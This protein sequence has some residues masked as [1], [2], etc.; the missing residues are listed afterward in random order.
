MMR[1]HI[2][3]YNDI[4]FRQRWQKRRAQIFRKT[5][6]CRST[7]IDCICSLSGNADRRQ[8]ST[9]GRRIDRSAV[10]CSFFFPG[11]GIMPCYICVDSAFIKKYQAVCGVLR[12]KL[13]P[14]FPFLLYIGDAP[15][16]KHAETS[17]YRH[18]QASKLF[19]VPFHH[20][21]GVGVYQ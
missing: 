1:T 13:L 15:V 21:H 9:I 8:N 10:N 17:F 7:L 12:Y 20:L 18:I 14:I 19:Y 2:I 6:C 3:H 4:C 5:F 11:T 16:P